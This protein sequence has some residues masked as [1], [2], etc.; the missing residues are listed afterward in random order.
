VSA[1]RTRSGIA[2]EVRGSGPALLLLHEGIAD[3]TMWDPQWE[4]WGEEFTLVR[5]DHRGFG[6]SDD[7]AGPY[8]AHTDAVEVLDAAEIERAAIVGASMGGQAAIDLVVEAPRRAWALVAVA[9]VPS[10]W[11]HSSDHLAMFD[12]IDETWETE[13]VDSANE[14]ELRMW[15]DGVGRGPLDS[16]QRAR[17]R[18]ERL[19]RALIERQGAWDTGI[20]PAQLVPPATERLDQIDLPV[21]VVTGAHDQPSVLAGA[22]HLAERTGAETAEIA[23]TAH[24]PNLERPKRFDAAVL[25]FLRRAAPR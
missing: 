7:P 9:A 19:N 4:S 13:G 17:R 23:G 6:E 20:E 11:R 21:L 18:I 3:R 25:P 1:A 8:G 24:V 10:G 14:L 5:S 22:A 12:E 16:D 2:Y 15:V